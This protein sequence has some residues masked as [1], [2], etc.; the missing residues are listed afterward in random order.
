MSNSAQASSL[1]ETAAAPVPGKA[2]V[3][4]ALPGAVLPACE[5][6]RV[7]LA[8]PANPAGLRRKVQGTRSGTPW[9][10]WPAIRRGDRSIPGSLSPAP[11]DVSYVV[12]HPQACHLPHPELT[13][14]S[15]TPSGEG[16]GILGYYSII[17]KEYLSID[18]TDASLEI[19]RNCYHNSLRRFSHARTIFQRYSVAPSFRSTFSIFL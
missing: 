4:R 9:V 13:V 15:R 10:P 16:G 2:R 3:A 12:P 17:V 1:V 6:W 19:D 8:A 7:R 14:M 11:G 18:G 5:G